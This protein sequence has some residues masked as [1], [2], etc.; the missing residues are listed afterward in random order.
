MF[1]QWHSKPITVFCSLTACTFPHNSSFSGTVTGRYVYGGVSSS[2][3]GTV[4][5]LLKHRSAN[6]L[7]QSFKMMRG[8]GGCMQICTLKTLSLGEKHARS[9]TLRRSCTQHVH[10]VALPRMSFHVRQRGCRYLALVPSGPASKDQSPC[11]PL[12]YSP[13]IHQKKYALE[14]E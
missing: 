13:M 5:K 3:C 2:L 9:L 12:I 14:K 11:S 8:W 4:I 7:P 10:D 1:R 6:S